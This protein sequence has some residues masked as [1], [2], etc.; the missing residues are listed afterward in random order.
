MW[1]IKDF[2]VWPGIKTSIDALHDSGNEY[3]YE[4]ARQDRVTFFFHIKEVFTIEWVLESQTV[5]QKSYRDVLI[6]LREILKKK[7]LNIWKRVSWNIQQDNPSVYN[8]CEAFFSDKHIPVL[9][10]PPY[11]PDYIPSDFLFSTA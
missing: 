4:W 8:D 10:H 7:R 9:R 1:W 3:K 6:K 11:S 2:S 5:N